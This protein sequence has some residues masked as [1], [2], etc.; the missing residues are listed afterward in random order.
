MAVNDGD[1]LKVVQSITCP[2][3]VHAQN[4][5]YW[6]LDDPTP[7]NPSTAQ[8]LAAIDTRL[9]DMYQKVNNE[10]SNAYEADNFTVERIEWNV[11]VWE[12][13]ENVGTGNIAIVGD[14][15]GDAAPH[16]CACVVTAQTSRP[17]TRARKFLPGVIEVDFEDSTLNGTVLGVLAQF[18]ISWLTAQ[19]VV[20]SAELVP[21]V[22]SQSGPTAGTIFALISAV[23]P[24]IVGYMRTRKPGV[25][26]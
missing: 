26:M 11:D 16:G 2:T 24:A 18:V 23:T 15:P 25:G 12:T 19:S 10:M 14:Q 5:Y 17:K 6:R 4:V 20:G 9:D 22:A 13:V 3:L 8:I 21:V 1:I 7:D